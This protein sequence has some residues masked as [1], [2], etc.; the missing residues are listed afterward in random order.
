MA[1][2][3]FSVPEYYQHFWTE[4][5]QERL[6]G[7]VRLSMFLIAGVCGGLPTLAWALHVFYHHHKSGGRIS[8]S[9]IMLL[10]CDLLVLLLVPYIVTNVWQDGFWDDMTCRTL[11]SLW[12]GAETYGL[13]LQQVV[14]LEGALSLRYPVTCDHPFFRSCSIMFSIIALVCFSLLEIIQ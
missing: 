13:H 11:S 3:L 10:S 8:A 2:I 7:K 1:Q 5:Q 4:T 12:A 9:I 14:G 6:A